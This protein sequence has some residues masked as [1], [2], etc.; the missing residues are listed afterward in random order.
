M[1]PIV[2]VSGR[3]QGRQTFDIRK[4]MWEWKKPRSKGRKRC[5]SLRKHRIP[6]NTN[7]NSSGSTVKLFTNFHPINRQNKAQWV[8]IRHRTGRRQSAKFYED[9]KSLRSYLR[10]LYGFPV[11]D[12]NT[13]TNEMYKA[14]EKNWGFAISLGFSPVMRMEKRADQN[15]P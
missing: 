4:A 11:S 12:E 1:S 13:W 8:P 5:N 3:G 7:S 2:P 9:Y 14:D 6:L 10:G 15:N